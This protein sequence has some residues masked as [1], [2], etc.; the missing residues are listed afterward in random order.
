MILKLLLKLFATEQAK[1]YFPIGS[2]ER[3]WIDRAAIWL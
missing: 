1:R 3:L 2:K